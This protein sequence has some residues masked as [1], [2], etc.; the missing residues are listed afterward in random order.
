MTSKVLYF[1]LSDNESAPPSPYTR[2]HSRS[3]DP[4]SLITI[5]DINCLFIDISSP[6]NSNY[7]GF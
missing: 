3:D 7:L 1:C 5:I 6:L 4:M 2:L